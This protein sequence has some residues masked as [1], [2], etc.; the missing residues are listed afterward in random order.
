MI[1]RMRGP[2][3]PVMLGELLASPLNVLDASQAKAIASTC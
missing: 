1:P 2:F 3:D